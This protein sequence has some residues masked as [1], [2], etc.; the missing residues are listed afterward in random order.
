M[1]PTQKAPVI[2]RNRPMTAAETEKA[3]SAAKTLYPQ[4]MPCMV[5]LHRW[6]QHSG[7]LCPSRPGY[8]SAITGLP[9]PPTYG[10]T[11]FVPDEMYFNQNPNFDVV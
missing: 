6:M 8:L 11:T 4:D 10:N 3:R 9:V 1:N 2:H 7:L 5:C